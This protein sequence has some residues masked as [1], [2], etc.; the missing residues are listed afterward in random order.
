L[1]RGDAVSDR[2]Y[3]A[4]FERASGRLFRSWASSLEAALSASAQ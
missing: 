2:V 1:E 4:R 3:S